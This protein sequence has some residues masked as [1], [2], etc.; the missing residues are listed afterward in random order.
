MEIKICILRNMEK[1]GR[2]KN[3]SKF[4]QIWKKLIGNKKTSL[5]DMRIITLNRKKWDRFIKG[6]HKMSRRSRNMEI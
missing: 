1:M 2:D 4:R 6:K 5:P 3:R